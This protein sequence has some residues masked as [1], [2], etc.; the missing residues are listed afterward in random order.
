MQ[1]RTRIAYTPRTRL[2]CATRMPRRRRPVSGG[3]HMSLQ[4]LAA[5][6]TAV[7]VPATLSSQSPQLVDIGTHKLD[8]LRAGTGTPTIVFEAGL[9][10]DGIDDWKKVWPAAAQMSSVVV[11]SRSGN[12]R[13]QVGP[14]DHSARTCATELHAL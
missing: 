6:L 10:D 11:Y 8:V 14:G 9:G 7:L 13:S 2:L 3:W 4:H 5:L 1:L 12:G